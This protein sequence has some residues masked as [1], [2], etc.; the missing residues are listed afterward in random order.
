MSVYAAVGLCVH[1]ADQ[2]AYVLKEVLSMKKHI[3]L[4]SLLP[5]YIL[6][7][8]VC[9][10]VAHFGSRA[11]TTMIETAPIQG[12]RIMIIDPGHGGIDG[13]ATSCSGVLESGLNLE[14]ALRLNDLLRF[15]GYETLMVRTTD[16][17]I[18]TQGNTIAAQKVSDLK[19]RV[20][21]VNRTENAL[22]ISIH[23]NAFPESK[24]SGAQVFYA[25][26]HFSKSLSDRLQSD[27][28][29]YL[30][31][32]SKRQSKPSTGIY[33]MQNIC[34]SGVLIECGFLSNPQEEALLRTA[35]Y[36]KKICC[37]IASGVSMG[38]D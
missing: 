28:R 22:L 37:I 38:E 4:G 16:T 14:I 18:H 29:A 17:S 9:L 34:R 5:I 27:F 36:Q 13:G 32:G 12:R 20:A 23:Q 11:V 1:F 33:L 7:I 26:D 10:C 6:A 3:P 8:I 15:L 2:G 35:Q 19:E 30:N 31:P 25:N 21:L 24:Y